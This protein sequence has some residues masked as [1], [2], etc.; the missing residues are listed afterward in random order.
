MTAEAYAPQPIQ[1]DTTMLDI[2]K[3]LRL[4]PKTESIVDITEA[5][6]GAEAANA[7]ALARIAEIEAGR[8]ALLAGG[9][10]AQILACETELA[11]LQAEASQMQA[12]ATGLAPRLQAATHKQQVEQLRALADEA[13]ATTKRFTDFMAGDY[14]DLAMRIAAGMRLELA[15]LKLNERLYEA[16]NAAPAASQ[17]AGLHRAPANPAVFVYPTGGTGME[18]TTVCNRISLPAPAGADGPGD[19]R[20]WLISKPGQH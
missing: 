14:A 19:G 10:E 5:I 20:A 15:A 8:P 6:A 18:T 1:E 13:N 3:I 7:A 17:E 16:M 9:S 12:L 11:A 2:R 4:R